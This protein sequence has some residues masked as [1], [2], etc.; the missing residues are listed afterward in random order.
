MADCKRLTF[1]YICDLI[2]HMLDKTD[3]RDRAR[4]FRTR[5]GEAMRDR[6]TSQSALARAI[7]VDRSTISQLLK[8]EGARL[9][10]AQRAVIAGAGHMVPVTHSRQVA[11]EILRF[12]PG[13]P[14][15]PGVPG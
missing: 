10:N 7:G 11:G 14:E 3:K 1:L 2:H 8:G 13:V 6:D 4:L 9:P 5:L 15:V 12:L